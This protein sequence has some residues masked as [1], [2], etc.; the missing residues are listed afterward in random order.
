M[1][2]ILELR[3][4]REVFSLSITFILENM[5]IS[6]RSSITSRREVELSCM[7]GIKDDEPRT[8]IWWKP[9]ETSVRH[10]S[11]ESLGIH[12]RVNLVDHSTIFP[13]LKLIR[14]DATHYTVL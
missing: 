11:Q 9:C 10:S 13:D 5:L 2:V 4:R 6:R 14:F 1:V 8:T 7:N 3:L 12:V